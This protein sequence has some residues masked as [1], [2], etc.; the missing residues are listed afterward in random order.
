MLAKTVWKPLFI[1]PFKQTRKLL[2]DHPVNLLKE[3]NF[4]LRLQFLSRLGH[5]GN[6]VLQLVANDFLGCC[7]FSFFCR[8]L[9]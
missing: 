6:R 2:L 8:L 9:C 4:A 5:L 3:E 7:W 1:Q